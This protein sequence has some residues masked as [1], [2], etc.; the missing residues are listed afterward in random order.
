MWNLIGKTAIVTGLPLL[1]DKAINFLFPNVE[2]EVQ[3][4]VQAKKAASRKKSDCTHWTQ[5]HYDYLMQAYEKHKQYNRDN[6]K[7]R[8]TQEDLAKTVNKKMGMNKSRTALARIWNGHVKRE[9]LPV[10]KPYFTYDD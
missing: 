1:I 9:D 8:R 10:G 2:E 3:E 5:F 4:A 7:K 6:P